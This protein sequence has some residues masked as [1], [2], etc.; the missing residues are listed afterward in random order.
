MKTIFSTDSLLKA[1][2]FKLQLET[3][4]FVIVDEV[5][6]ENEPF[7]DKNG[8]LVEYVDVTDYHYNDKDGF[9]AGSFQVVVG[10]SVTEATF[11]EYGKFE[12]F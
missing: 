7:F 8:V 10:D 1:K 5:K 11:L 3:K 2:N 6:S 4:G 9:Y 12:E